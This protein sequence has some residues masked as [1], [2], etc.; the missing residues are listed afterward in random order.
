M[1]Q[2]LDS[3]DELVEVDVQHPVAHTTFSPGG[4]SYPHRFAWSLKPNV[5]YLVLNFCATWKKQTTL[6]SMAVIGVRQRRCRTGG[7]TDPRTQTTARWGHQSCQEGSEA[8]A[9]PAGRPACAPRRSPRARDN[10][11]RQV[12]R[13]RAVRPV[14]YTHLTLPTILRV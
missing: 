8:G 4:D 10:P 14:S 9:R 7:L 12:P 3:R 2:Q 13:P 1:A 6:P 5:A 11:P